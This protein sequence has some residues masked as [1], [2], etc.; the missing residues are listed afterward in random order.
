MKTI[1]TSLYPRYHRI[2]QLVLL[3]GIQTAAFAGSSFVQHN[4][5]SDIP[6]LADQTDPN[7]VNPWGIAAS[8]TSPLWISNNGSSAATVYNGSGQ[9]FPAANPLVVQIPTSASGTSP[10]APTGE[11]FNPTSAFLLP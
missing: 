7:L 6:G 9:P 10:L 8:A 1:R 5:V 4:L 11:V 2:A 3:A